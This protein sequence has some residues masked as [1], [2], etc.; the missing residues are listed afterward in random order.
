M[1]TRPLPSCIS[2]HASFFEIAGRGREGDMDPLVSVS[3]I[4][5]R[6]ALGSVFLVAGYAKIQQPRRVRKDP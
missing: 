3:P 5:A 1:M 6:I 4:V 2:T